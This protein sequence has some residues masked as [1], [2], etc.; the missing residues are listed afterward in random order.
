MKGRGHSGD[1]SVDGDGIKILREMDLE[2]LFCIHFTQERGCVLL[3]N[4]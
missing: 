1:L 4:R 3:R 2:I